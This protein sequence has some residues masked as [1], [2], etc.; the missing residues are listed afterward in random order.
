VSIDF[1]IFEL[2]FLYLSDLSVMPQSRR[3]FEQLVSSIDGS[4]TAWT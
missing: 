4:W 2:I 3:Y 1:L